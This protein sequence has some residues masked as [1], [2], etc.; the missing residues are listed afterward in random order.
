MSDNRYYVNWQIG[1]ERFRCCSYKL[2]KNFRH[3]KPYLGLDNTSQ[4]CLFTCHQRICQILGGTFCEIPAND[5]RI[6]DRGSNDWRGKKIAV[7]KNGHAP[8]I[9]ARRDP[10]GGFVHAI[11]AATIQVQK[12]YGFISRAAITCLGLADV[13]FRDDGLAIYAEFLT[14]ARVD[15]ESRVNRDATHHFMDANRYRPGIID[16]MGVRFTTSG[17]KN[18]Q[19]GSNQSFLHGARFYPGKSA[20][21]FFFCIAGFPLPIKKDL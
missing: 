6:L 16:I 3:H 4:S 8:V 1:T 12:D 21:R 20:G 17:T 10:L 13:G 9:P 7:D 5:Q 18:N 11:P 19:Y 2:C 15:H 14:G